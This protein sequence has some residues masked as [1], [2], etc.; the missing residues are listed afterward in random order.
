ML[1]RIRD[2][3]GTAGLIVAVVALIAALGGGA[4]AATSDGGKATASKAGKR[5]P[6]GPKGATGPAGPQGAPGAPGTNGTNGKDGAAGKDGTNGKTV[7]VT[8]IE[9]EEPGCDELGGAEVKQ[10]GAAEGVEVCNGAPWTAGGTLPPGS[11]ETGVWAIAGEGNSY[12]TFSFAI[13]LSG[14]LDDTHVH[15]VTSP[16]GSCTGT[17]ENPTAASGHLCVYKGKESEVFLQPILNPNTQLEGAGSTGG[18]M[19]V[20]G[21]GTEAN[22]S[23]TW[24]VTG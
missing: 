24:A 10:Q 3:L 4:L 11:T 1:N 2:Q 12:A 13:P 6:K 14:P 22:A 9:P 16:G 17:A 21:F 19:N 8:E 7:A 18:I 23:G 15:Y 5:G 20:V